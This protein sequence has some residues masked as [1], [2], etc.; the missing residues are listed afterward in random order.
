MQVEIN[1]EV[2]GY[3]LREAELMPE[4][5][6]Q[7]DVLALMHYISEVKSWCGAVT[8]SFQCCFPTEVLRAAKESIRRGD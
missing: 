6:K 2:L 3:A 1:A 4:L 7:G 8:H 5:P